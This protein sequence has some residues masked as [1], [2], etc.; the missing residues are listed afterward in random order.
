MSIFLYHLVQSYPLQFE[1]LNMKNAHLFKS[2]IYTIAQT[3]HRVKLYHSLVLI[4]KLAEEISKNKVL[5]KKQ[6]Y[7]QLREDERYT[8]Y[9][10]L[11]QGVSVRK[12][13]KMLGRHHST[14]YREIKRNKGQKGYRPRNAILKSQARR[15]KKPKQINQFGKEYIKHLIQQDWS[16]EQV[17]GRLKELGFINVP[18]YE[19][20]YLYIY[21]LKRQGIDLTPHLRQQKPY[22]KRNLKGQARRGRILNKPTIHQRPAVINNR[23]RTG[24]FEG[25]TIIGKDR[26]GVVVT[27][28]CRKSLFVQMK[29]LPNKK[30]EA[31]INAF[32]D[33]AKQ[34]Q[35]H[36]I[37]LDNGTEF[38]AYQRLIDKDI[39]VFFAD[40]YCSNQRAR[41]ENTNGLIRQYLKKSMRLDNINDEQIAFIENR[42]NNRPRKSLGYKTPNEVMAQCDLIV[43]AA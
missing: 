39:E 28:V 29:T 25:D 4:S 14:I 8:I 2:R 19:W 21:Q 40:P 10:E 7:S 13:A 30:T 9:E 33:F 26:K 3:L 35:I 17:S 24:D 37:T 36:S 42:L 6:Q 12:I 5:H 34:T 31:V 16:P 20:I 1:R 27:N 22:R 15:Y 11:L 18:S 38:E 32:L 41:N 23:E 43:Q